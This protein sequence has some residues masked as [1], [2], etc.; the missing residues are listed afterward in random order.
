MALL[1]HHVAVEFFG[2]EFS[3]QTPAEHVMVFGAT[4]LAVVLMA[5]GL[6]AVVRDLLRWRR[7]RVTK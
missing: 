3:P 2:R 1:G 7:R 6:F 5:Y 4:A